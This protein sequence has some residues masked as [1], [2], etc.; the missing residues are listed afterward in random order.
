MRWTS[1]PH[2]LLPC[3]ALPLRLARDSLHQLLV[4]LLYVT[5]L[6]ELE[7][8]LEDPQ[9]RVRVLVDLLAL[10]PELCQVL[11][12]RIDLLL[13]HCRLSPHQLPQVLH[14]P[15]VLPLQ[16]FGPV[17]Q[18]QELL[19]EALQEVQVLP[20]V[21]QLILHSLQGGNER[22]VRTSLRSL[23]HLNRHGVLLHHRS[24]FLELRVNPVEQVLYP[25]VGLGDFVGQVDSSLPDRLVEQADAQHVVEQVLHPLPLICIR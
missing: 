20:S 2:C 18:A 6:R 19:L 9:Q 11:E 14:V 25:R 16:V 5:R 4:Q 13:G 1:Y 24:C 3:L 8:V 7:E 23:H 22:L 10:H 17:A 12:Q 15:V 21:G